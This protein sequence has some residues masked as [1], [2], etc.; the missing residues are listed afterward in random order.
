M[1]DLPDYILRN[2]ASWDADAL[3]WVDGGRRNW[4]SEEPTWGVFNIPESEAG[5][6]PA[7]LAGRDVI[8]LDCGTAYVSAWLARRGAR[9]VG[10]DNS[11]KQLATAR[12]LQQEF[13]ID[14][15]LIHG[16]AET[17]PLPSESFDI[18]ISE[19][20]AA[21]WADPY[22]WIPE[23]SRLLRPGGQLVFL[24]N[25]NLMMLV[26]PETDDEGP[27]TDRLIR[28]QFGMHRFDWPEEQSVEFHISHGD[29]I[30]LLRANHFEV[31]DLIELRPPEGA[32]TTY[33]WVTLDWA[34]KW[35]AE[36]VWKARKLAPQ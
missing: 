9:P 24:G 23:A 18:A 35:P 25:S 13:G 33:P 21:I 19:Y 17:V 16:N 11:E 32:T 2:R 31:E 5:V 10:I 20:G 36:E 34:R 7:D 22:R 27:A 3:N 4:A 8:E 14:F 30:R 1:T 12:A 28:P 29:W 26:I 6:L 15:P